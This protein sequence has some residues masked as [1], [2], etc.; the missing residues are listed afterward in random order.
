M[1][2]LENISL[3]CIYCDDIRDETNGKTTIVGWYG[4]EHVQ[5][6]LDGPLLLTSLCMVGLV[7]MPLTPSD[8]SFRL[9]LMQGTDVLQSVNIPPEAVEEMQTNSNGQSIGK[10][11]R[12]A[13]KMAN[14]TVSE[15]CI[16]RLRIVVDKEEI[17]GNGLRFTRQ[18]VHL[19]TVVDASAEKEL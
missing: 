6:P 7:A 19:N 16:L 8:T 17:Y 9:D 4:G 5:L 18:P 13:I 15:P 3:Q 1:K 11:I 10:Q 12:I 14:M 2:P